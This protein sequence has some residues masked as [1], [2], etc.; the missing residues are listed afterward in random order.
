MDKLTSECIPYSG[1]AFVVGRGY[2]VPPAASEV[3]AL[4]LAL[5][6]WQSMVTLRYGMRAAD[7]SWRRACKVVRDFERGV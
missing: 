3:D 5:L 1:P 6:R 4:E 2:V 7:Q